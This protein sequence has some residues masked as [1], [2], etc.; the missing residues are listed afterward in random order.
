MSRPA[1][2]QRRGLPRLG[3][4][5]KGRRQKAGRQQFNGRRAD[6]NAGGSVEREDRRGKGVY[7]RH[8]ADSE[9]ATE[10]FEIDEGH[11]IDELGES[12]IR[13]RPFQIGR[14]TAER[15]DRAGGREVQQ[16]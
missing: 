15:E 10:V 3:A 12:G 6:I 14:A 1:R 4:A 7:E 5:A 9:G 8:N 13:Q 11:E 16:G 2:W